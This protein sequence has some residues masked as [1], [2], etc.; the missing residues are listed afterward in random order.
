MDLNKVWGCILDSSCLG[1]SPVAGSCE[2]SRVKNEEYNI[3]YCSESL[4]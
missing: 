2:Q 4:H 3:I 1:K